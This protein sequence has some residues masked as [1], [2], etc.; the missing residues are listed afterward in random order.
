MRELKCEGMD[1]EDFPTS[2]GR[3][4]LR[5]A[6]VVI[7]CTGQAGLITGEM[8]KNGFMAIDVGYPKP[9]FTPEAL[10]KARFYTPVPGGVGPVTVVMLFKNLVEC[11]NA[12]R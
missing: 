8:V 12:N 5:R 1:K 4:G 6:G 10:A 2:S 7:S 11:V 9:E 3:A